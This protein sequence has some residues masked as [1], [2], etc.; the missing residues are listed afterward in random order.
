MD[1]ETIQKIEL[2]GEKKFT[3]EEW[4]RL[5]DDP[6]FAKY[7]GNLVSDTWQNETG[8]DIEKA[9]EQKLISDLKVSTN[10]SDSV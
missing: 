4:E 8:D 9:L 7:F 2:G 10:F 3:N 5:S 6:L 1:R